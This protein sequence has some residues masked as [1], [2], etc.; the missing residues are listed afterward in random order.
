VSNE[1]VPEQCGV[2]RVL[3]N[4]VLNCAAI[5]SNRSPCWSIFYQPDKKT[6]QSDQYVES[7][8]KPT[9]K[10]RTFRHRDKTWTDVGQPVPIVTSTGRLFRHAD[11][12]VSCCNSVVGVLP[13]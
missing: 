2:L 13:V 7:R 10:R 3:L 4:N 1:Q 8:T 9:L 11:E 5:L 6:L 12:V